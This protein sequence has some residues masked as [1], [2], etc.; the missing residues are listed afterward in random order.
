MD[1]IKLDYR[2]PAKKIG[3]LLDIVAEFA[4]TKGKYQDAIQHYV[5][6]SFLVK[7]TGKPE[8]EL[9]R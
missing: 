5:D 1:N 8:Q 6:Y 3:A 7:A 2:M 9:A 4:G